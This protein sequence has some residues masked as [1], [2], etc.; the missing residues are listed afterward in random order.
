MSLRTLIRL[1]ILPI[2][3]ILPVAAVRDRS[4]VDV[5]SP[6][7]FSPPTTS[8]EIDDGTARLVRGLQAFQAAE[9][10][11]AIE[12]LS[13]PAGYLDDWRLLVLAESSHTLGD[14]GQAETALQTLVDQFPDSPIRALAIQRAAEIA[15]EHQLWESSVHWMDFARAEDL[16]QDKARA[17]ETLAWETGAALERRD[18]QVS[19]GRQLLIEHPV[20]AKELAVAAFFRD[21]S[22][23]VDWTRTL[24]VTEL[25][26]RARRQIESRQSA[27]ALETLDWVPADQRSFDWSLLRAEAFTRDHRGQEALEVLD[28]LT[29]SDTERR[30]AIAWQRSLAARETARVRRGRS[31]LPQG[32]REKMRA[33]AR[34][35]LS[36]V[37]ALTPDPQLRLDALKILFILVSDQEDSFEPS[38][39]V[40]Q[41]LRGLNPKDTSG[42]RY[43]WRLGWQAYAKRDYPVA[44]GYWSELESLYPG[45]SNARSGRYWTGR[46]HEA[47]GHETRALGIYR[48]ILSSQADDFYSRHARTRL[49]DSD[50]SA[51]ESP[52]RPTEP[53]PE[54][55]LLDRA[56]WLRSQSL[57]D[58][59]LHELDGQ[60]PVAEHQAFCAEKALV[61]SHLNR[62]RDSIQ[63]LACA[64]PALGKA[65][66]SI[67][68]NDALQLYYPLDFRPII[69][70][71]ASDQSLSPYLVFAMVR[72]E[73][74]F[75]AEARSWAGARGLMQLMP[76]TGR[77]VA[78][79]LGLSYSTSRL[80]E[81]DFSVR[82]GTRYFRQVLD[83]FD[84]NVE[85]A[86]AGYNGGP[87]RI[88]K[89]WR[90]AGRDPEL[91]R[92]VEGLSLEETKTYV[93][94]ILLF[95]D[96]YQ[97][98]YS[99][100]G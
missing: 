91:D 31:N 93:K 73:S 88:K 71:R 10:N 34:A 42:T 76:A 40:L 8:S 45:T 4:P 86:L 9:M 17:I 12:M 49:D 5:S 72:Q 35:S 68:P 30:V 79:R 80:N 19:A 51:T 22:G 96:S 94:R 84:G 14:P 16:P 36:E 90:Q 64:F 63:A 25:E 38:L 98:L 15:A 2:A 48:E 23:K 66:Q 56:R 11:D 52:S 77:E 21:D 59:A 33:Q 7:S 87:Y 81:P 50:R 46:S 70:Q 28:G 1:A 43:L 89:L 26:Q 57:Y 83:M 41:R 3:V 39:E 58:L 69:E 78:Q 29:S 67:V 24:E 53:W 75:D 20:E 65:Y 61:L 32:R 37:A 92:F 74:A 60:E 85:L 54:D 62:R 27:E 47:L 99:A 13:E 55:P 82:L 6:E 44:I 18:L 95:E 100:G 97:Q